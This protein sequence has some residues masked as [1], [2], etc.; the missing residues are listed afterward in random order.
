[1]SHTLRIS[2]LIACAAAAA[3]FAQQHQHPAGDKLGTVHFETSC[4]A[5]AQPSFDRA[6]A[7]LHSFEFGSAI[8]AFNETLKADP[9]CAMAH[10]GIAMARWTNPYSASIRPPAQLQQGLDAITLARKA[11]AKTERERA[12]IDAAAKLYTDAGTL[13]QR[14]RIVKPRSSGPCR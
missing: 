7:L 4:A 9:S 3:P 12:Y 2:I 8:T 13:D 10:W 1:M 6:M 5:A 11:G 14:A